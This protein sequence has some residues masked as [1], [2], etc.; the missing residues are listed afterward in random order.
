[1]GRENLDIVGDVQILQV[2]IACS[3]TPQSER[4]PM[5]TLTSVFMMAKSSTGVGYFAE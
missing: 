3:M 1:M 5:M 2:L 4:E